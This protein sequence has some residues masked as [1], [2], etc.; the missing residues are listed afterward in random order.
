MQNRA[1][2]PPNPHLSSSRGILLRKQ[3]VQLPSVDVWPR[4]WCYNV[5]GIN[6]AWFHIGLDDVVVI[7]N[8]V[9][10]NVAPISV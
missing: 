9:L 3:T 6:I 1:P 8:R 5:L 7:V 2:C 4:L 10:V